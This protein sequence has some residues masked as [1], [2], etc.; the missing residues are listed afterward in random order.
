[1]EGSAN[2]LIMPS[3]DAAHISYN[4]LKVLGDGLPVGPAL[5]GAAGARNDGVR[6]C[7]GLAQYDG[8]GCYRSAGGGSRIGKAG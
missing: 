5:I 4:L 7:A 8:V 2:L 3:L 1:M 6:D